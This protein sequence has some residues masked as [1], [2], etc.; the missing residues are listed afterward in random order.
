MDERPTGE[1]QT[2]DDETPV[3]TGDI[4]LPPAGA[5]DHRYRRAEEPPGYYD[6][7]GGQ[8]YY[9]EEFIADIIRAMVAGFKVTQLSRKYD[10]PRQTIYRWY[11]EAGRKRRGGDPKSVIRA[12]GQV[13]L[14]LETAA[15]ECW[16]VI[17]ENP[18]TELALKGVNSLV[19]VQRH[20]ALLLGLNAPV[21]AQVSVTGGDEKDAE[22]RDMINVAKA[23]AAGDIDRIRAE[24]EARQG[25]GKDA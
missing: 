10:I 23:T 7:D 16:R 17:R 24:F 6:S 19:N 3:L 4:V 14:E 15:G 5:R 11:Q 12:R 13:A 21:V 9:D 8:R 1:P 22:L 20:R 2:P 18:G 25:G